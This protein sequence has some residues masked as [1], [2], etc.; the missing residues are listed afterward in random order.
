MCELDYKESWTPKNWCFW[1]V[2][3]EK[4]LESPLD[5]KEVQ[6][7]HP[8]GD[9]CWVYTCVF[10]LGS[11][12]SFLSPHWIQAGHQLQCRPLG[13]GQS[14]CRNWTGFMVSW[15][16]ITNTLAV[17]TPQHMAV[18]GL[19]A[20][21]SK[22]MFSSSPVGWGLELEIKLIYRKHR[23]VIFFLHTQ[24]FKLKYMSTSF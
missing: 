18:A 3:L 8:K 14:Q 23:N 13:G 1:T 11:S 19:S 6:P 9:H 2:V 7:V 12:P 17:A 24:V 10:I 21:L 4:T 22:G 5:W 16:L 15:C 20:Y